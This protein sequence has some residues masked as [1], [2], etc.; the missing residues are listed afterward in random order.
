M[1]IIT[2][3]LLNL[4][5]LFIG[6]LVITSCATI[7][8]N[9]YKEA[10]ATIDGQSKSDIETLFGMEGHMQPV[11]DVVADY[12]DKRFAKPYEPS[13]GTINVLSYHTSFMKHI[14]AHMTTY[15]VTEQRGMKSTP[16]GGSVPN[17][18]SVPKTQH[19]PAQD[20]RMY[21]DTFFD[22]NS[23]GMVIGHRVD[24]NDCKEAWALEAGSFATYKAKVEPAEA[25]D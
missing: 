3:K 5:C 7:Q 4:A 20:V 16:N 10:L 11:A 19:V 9:A 18:V 14:P 25:S 23:A 22:L 17:M 6:L 13:E 12:A 21:C 24:G 2:S 8:R 1:R 15:M